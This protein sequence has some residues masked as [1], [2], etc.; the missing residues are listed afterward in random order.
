VTSARDHGVDLGVVE[1]EERGVEIFLA[2]ALAFG[3]DQRHRRGD[4]GQ[5]LQAKEVELDQADLLHVVHVELRG[6]G[7]AFLAGWTEARHILPQR[8]FADDHARGVCAGVAVQALQRLGD[9]EQL[10]VLAVVKLL[11][12]R[13]VL[14]GLG[15]RR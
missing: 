6:Q 2:L 8:L 7:F 11:Q 3:I 9:V 14:D 13:L 15:Q 10:A 5:R 1:R 4:H 12:T